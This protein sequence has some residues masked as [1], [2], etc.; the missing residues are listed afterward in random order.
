MRFFVIIVAIAFIG[1]SSNKQI[2]IKEG[3]WR[4]VI[5][6]QGHELPFNFKIYKDSTKH[7]TAS[8]INADEKIVLDEVVLN[9]DS[10]SMTLHVFDSQ[11]KARITGDSLKGFFIKNYEKNYKLP[12]KAAF[13]QDF[14]FVEYDSSNSQLPDYT[15]KY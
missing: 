9:G 8:I 12:F 1:C 3:I 14:R 7:L 2:N 15:G 13:G 11:L 5:D 10:I 6:I 4:G